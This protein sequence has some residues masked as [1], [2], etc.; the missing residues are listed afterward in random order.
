MQYNYF[1]LFNKEKR[2]FNNFFLNIIFV[3]SRNCEFAD[4]QHEKQ[5]LSIFRNSTGGNND[6]QTKMKEETSQERFDVL[7][8]IFLVLQTRNDLFVRN[9]RGSLGAV[10]PFDLID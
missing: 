1:L 4:V 7:H 9:N 10:Q 6:E 2:K 3:H 8:E 5:S